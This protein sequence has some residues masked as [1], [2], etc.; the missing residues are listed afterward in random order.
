MHYTL[1]FKKLWVYVV[2]VYIVYTFVVA[3]AFLSPS[4]FAAVL[5]VVGGVIVMWCCL[6]LGHTHAHVETIFYI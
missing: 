4:P 1:H 2:W 3:E 6:L 5:K